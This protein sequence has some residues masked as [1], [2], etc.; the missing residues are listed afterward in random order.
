MGLV[1]EE[2]MDSFQEFHIKYLE[3]LLTQGHLLSHDKNNALWAVQN[4]LTLWNIKAIL[5]SKGS[6]IKE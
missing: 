4:C 6:L 3:S 2:K 5:F 1:Q